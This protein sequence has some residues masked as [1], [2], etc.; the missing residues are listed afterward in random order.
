[1]LSQKE[2]IMGKFF[3]LAYFCIGVKFWTLVSCLF[4]LFFLKRNFSKAVC[5]KSS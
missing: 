4:L 1:M 2:Y 5:R 3:L